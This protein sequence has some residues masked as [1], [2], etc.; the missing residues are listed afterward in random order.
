MPVAAG[1]SEQLPHA[2]SAEV[3]FTGMF[4]EPAGT[5]AR[6]MPRR[7][8][9]GGGL[10]GLSTTG[11]VA[12]TSLPLPAGLIVTSI[13]TGIGNTGATGPTHFWMAL[14]DAQLNVLAVTADQTG[15]TQAAG[16]A[17]KA[18]VTIPYQVSQTGLYYVAVSSSASTTAPT[19]AGAGVAITVV[20]S[21]IGAPVLCGTAGSQTTPPAIGTQLNSGTI[22]GTGSCNFAAW[23]S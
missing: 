15:A 18:A 23:I 19:L 10:S 6:T 11:Q 22:T 1:Y 9:T 17:I 7:L 20:I 4:D 3:L 13:M 21:A 8:V 12:V 16:S 14:T 2:G 5:L